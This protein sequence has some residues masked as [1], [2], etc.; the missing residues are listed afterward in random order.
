MWWTLIHQ[1]QGTTYYD[2][3]EEI[4]CVLIPGACVPS[5]ITRFQVNVTASYAGNGRVGPVISRSYSSLMY[6]HVYRHLPLD[7]CKPAHIMYIHT[8]YCMHGIGVHKVV[9]MGCVSEITYI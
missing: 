4:M 1:T 9:Y 2:N 8:Q 6:I 7:T 5:M 3:T